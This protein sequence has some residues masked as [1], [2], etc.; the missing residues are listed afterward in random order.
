[1]TRTRSIAAL[2]V[3]V[4]LAIATTAGT[5]IPEKAPFGWYDSG[6]LSA[7]SGGSVVGYFAKAGSLTANADSS[8][9]YLTDFHMWNFKAG[10]LNVRVYHP[11]GTSQAG[12]DSA[13]TLIFLQNTSAVHDADEWH[14]PE[15][16]R[17]KGFDLRTD[18]GASGVLWRGGK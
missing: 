9:G 12:T 1:M 6:F 15:G 5:R 18:P 8:I 16:M 11:G 13:Y 10:Q 3:L 14:A 4:V 17:V 7:V 2:S